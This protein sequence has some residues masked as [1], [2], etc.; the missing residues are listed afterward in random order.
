MNTFQTI[1]VVVIL[2]IIAVVG[3]M[4][5][6]YDRKRKLQYREIAEQ[7]GFTTLS[8]MPADVL[9]RIKRTYQTSTQVKASNISQK[10]I[11]GRDVY[12]MD[13]SYTNMRAENGEVEYRMICMIHEQLNLP[14]FLMLY[15]FEEVYGVAGSKIN[16]LMKIAIELLGMKK[17]SFNHP[18]FEKKYQVYG[19]ME[20]EIR[21]VFT[22]R[23]LMD[24]SGTDQWLIRAEGDCVCFNTYTVQKG[25]QLTFEQMQNQ[26]ASA[27]DLLGWLTE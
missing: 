18:A 7:L 23:L 11:N 25:G 10:K 2:G 17:I 26:L 27:Q 19:F 14:F 9:K 6:Q 12:L 4:M 1:F 16:R 3:F 22:P 15:Q 20:E 8:K 13:I 24:F 5:I 21:K